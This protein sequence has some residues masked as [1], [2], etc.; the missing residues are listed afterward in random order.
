VKKQLWTYCHYDQ[1]WH[2]L[3][4]HA[5]RC[6]HCG[7]TLNHSAHHTEAFTRNPNPES[8]PTTADDLGA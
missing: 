4:R 6:P 7:A 1:F 3:R 8:D 2:R 5:K